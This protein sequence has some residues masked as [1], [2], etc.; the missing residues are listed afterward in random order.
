MRNRNRKSKKIK[1][2]DFESSRVAMIEVF[3]TFVGK[4]ASGHSVS[5]AEPWPTRVAITRAG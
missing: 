4:R 1:N 3:L 5:A 2:R